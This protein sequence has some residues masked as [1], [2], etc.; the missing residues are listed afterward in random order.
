MQRTLVTLEE[1]AYGGSF[2]RYYVPTLAPRL[3][4]SYATCAPIPRD[5][6]AP[7]TM[8]TFPSRVGAMYEIS[9]QMSA[10]SDH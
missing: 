2:N 4:N 7:V 1:E 5:R 10:I 8:A 3:A 6:E 9:S